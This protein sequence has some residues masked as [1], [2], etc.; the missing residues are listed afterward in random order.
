MVKKIRACVEKIVPRIVKFRREIHSH[1]EL[2]G[3]EEK[4]A[5]FVAGVLEDNDIEVRTG[6]AGHGVVG[7]LRGGADGG[8]STEAPTVALRADLDALPLTDTKE[9]EYASKV[10][11]VLHACGHDVHTAVLMGT[12]VVL[13]SLKD[14]LKG[15]VKFIFQPSEESS[16]GGAKF[17]IEE[18]ALEDP[19][20]SAIFALHCYP[21]LPCGKVGHRAGI[22]TA[23]SDRFTITVKG[24]SGHASRPHQAVDA[25][26]VSSMVISAIHHIV[27]RKTDP[28]HHAVIS[29]G[30]I[31]GGTA[32]NIVADRVKMHGTVRTLDAKVREKI[33]IMMEDIIRGITAGTDAEYHFSYAFGSPSVMNDPELDK[34]V[35][36]SSEAVVGPENTVELKDPQMGAEDFAYFAERIPGAFLR[37]GTTNS[38]KGITTPLHTTDF[39]VDEDSLAI[40]TTLMSHLAMSYLATG[41]LKGKSGP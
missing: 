23:S 37:L 1:P 13:S 25:V 10:H 33:P 41:Y 15:N 39:D 19:A 8:L 18:G 28:L 6:V 35:K 24:R 16:I 22:M 29:I 3:A 31:E 2:S 34:L 12:A 14:I 26:L 36:R 9:T 40:G 20:P 4:T 17:M 32:A 5:S 21:E 11:G 30:T 27:S 7:V 38:D